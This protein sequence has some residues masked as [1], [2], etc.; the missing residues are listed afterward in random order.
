MTDNND[1]R[2]VRDFKFWSVVIAKNHILPGKCI[3]WCKR[4]DA[5]DPADASM[6]EWQEA[7]LIIKLLKSTVLELY[8]AD[9]FNYTFL[10]N[11]T[12]HLHMHFVPRYK[13]ERDVHG[14]SFLDRDWGK[15][16]TVDPN[17]KISSE[18]LQSIKT[19]MSEKINE[20]MKTNSPS[21]L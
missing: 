17:F 13:T 18:V 15:E 19:E 8:Q 2:L 20:L 21:P 14:M 16:Y 6:E 3:L 1:D 4:E 11:S 7:H 12:P 10:G 5:L 9:W